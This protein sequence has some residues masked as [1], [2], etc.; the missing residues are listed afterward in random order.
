ML[1]IKHGTTQC[2]LFT[3]P[4]GAVADQGDGPQGPGPPLFLDQ[5]EAERD[6]KKFFETAPPPRLLLLSECTEQTA[7]HNYFFKAG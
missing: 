1:Q 7:L 4:V 2:Q 6:E 3:N 5:T